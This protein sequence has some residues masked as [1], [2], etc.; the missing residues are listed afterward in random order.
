M[1]IDE[2]NVGPKPPTVLFELRDFVG[3]GSVNMVVRR[4]D[5][6]RMI[7]VQTISTSWTKSSRGGALATLRSRVPSR[8]HLQMPTDFTDLVWHSIAY[9]ERNKFVEPIAVW[10]SAHCENNRFGCRNAEIEFR[11]DMVTLVYRYQTG[12]PERQLYD[13]TGTCVAV[14]HAISIPRNRWASIE[15][16]SRYT[17]IDTGNWWYEHVV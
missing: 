3:G 10:V 17:C 14:E 15:Y 5:Q 16:N 13:D 1:T 8:L 11:D 2:Q 12:A 4:Q 6:A 7:A 9:S